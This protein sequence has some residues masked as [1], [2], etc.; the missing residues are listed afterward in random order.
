MHKQDRVDVAV[1]LGTYVSGLRPGSSCLCCGT[2]LQRAE[3]Q[4]VGPSTEKLRSQGEETPVLTCPD[5]GC[6]VGGLFTQEAA[7]SVSRAL[8]RAA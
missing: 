5:C 4:E 1:T 7:P 6:E 3:A 8:N 2:P